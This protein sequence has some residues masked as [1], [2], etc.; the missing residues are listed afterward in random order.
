MDST[1]TPGGE[2]KAKRPRIGSTPSL[3]GNEGGERPNF[4]RVPYTRRDNDY[5]DDRENRRT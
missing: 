2:K 1:N 3:A 4:E 5:A